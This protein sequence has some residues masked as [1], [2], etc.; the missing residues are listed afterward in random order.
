[1]AAYWVVKVRVT[2]PEAYGEYVKRVPPVVQQF[3]GRARSR[4]QAVQPLRK[5]RA[6]LPELVEIALRAEVK[7]LLESGKAR[8]RRFR[9]RDGFEVNRLD[10]LNRFRQGVLQRGD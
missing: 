1:M 7:L 10:M 8:M 9:L 6:D 3:G 4:L 2:D 5:N